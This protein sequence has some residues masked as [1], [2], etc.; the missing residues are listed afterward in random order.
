M[1]KSR[2]LV[3]RRIGDLWLAV[4]AAPP[5]VTSFNTA[6][7]EVAAVLS[8]MAV[9]QLGWYMVAVDIRQGRLRHLLPHTTASYGGVYMYYRQRTQMPQRVRQFIDYAVEHA[10]AQFAGGPWTGST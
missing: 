6:E 4:C 3:S 8:G 2:V 9:G 1:D 5:S 10:P 7:A